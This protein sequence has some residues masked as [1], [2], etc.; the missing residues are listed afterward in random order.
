[1]ERE[2]SATPA[3]D[4]NERIEQECYRPVAAARVPGAGG[5]IARILNLYEWVSFNFGPTLLEWLEDAAPD[6]Y[7]AILAA[8]RASAARVGHGNAIA[9]PYHHAILPL[10]SRR[11]KVTEVRWGI[12]DFERRFGRAPA[13]MWLP[14]TA[15]DEE[16][17]DVLAQ[18]GIRF[19]ILAP[20][21]VDPVP[22]AGRPA[23]VRTLGGRSITVF[24][25]D[26]AI[27]H[28]VAF[29]P[30]VRDGVAWGTRM[31]E[32]HA[33]AAGPVLV[34]AAT[35]GETFGHHRKGAMEGFLIPF[36]ETVP[37]TGGARLSTLSEVAEAFPAREAEVPRGSWSTTPD[38]LDRGIPWPLW[39]DPGNPDHS[40]L[41]ALRDLVLP[42][43]RG[44]AGADVA[45]LAD[46]MLYSCP[47]WWA[48][49]GRYDAVQVRRGVGSMLEAA[50]AAFRET[51]DRKR[52]DAVLAAA[53]AVPSMSRRG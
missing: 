21:Q 43:A 41:Y 17:L 37:E 10:S 38:D 49:G 19:T 34:S 7:A 35:D 14:E 8:D 13:G 5:R 22:P 31:L 4:W 51:G 28:D 36:L 2:P 11:E 32:R 52:L 12:A 3:H 29:G 1:V 9:M 50:F 6:T 30:L 26:G 16:T 25:Y 48:S 46:V 47:F 45:G 27:S 53:G 23:L 44:C 20:T 18:A 24:V 33:D 39:S 40:A 42:W 15:V